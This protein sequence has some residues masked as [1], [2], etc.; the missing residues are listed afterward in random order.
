MCIAKKNVSAL[1]SK[2][3]LPWNC[4][5]LEMIPD[6]R[7]GEKAFYFSRF[8]SYATSK[9]NF[10]NFSSSEF[11]ILIL[12][13]SLVKSFLYSTVLEWRTEPFKGLSKISRSRTYTILETLCWKITERSQQKTDFQP[14]LDTQ[15]PLLSFKIAL[16]VIK[17]Q[18]KVLKLSVTSTKIL[19]RMLSQMSLGRNITA[20]LVGNIWL[21]LNRVKQTEIL[22]HCC[23]AVPWHHWTREEMFWPH[24]SFRCSKTR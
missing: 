22:L 23:L 5:C 11:W 24:K 13:C 1:F 2:L 17:Y 6:I 12:I 19:P 9:G 4:M 15:F 16:L 18:T 21:A 7:K 8:L 20:M 14:V 3:I 10:T